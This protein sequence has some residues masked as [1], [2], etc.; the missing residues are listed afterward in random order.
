MFRQKFTRI[1]LSFVC[2]KELF[3]FGDLRSQFFDRFSITV[4]SEVTSAS[5]P[6]YPRDQ[7]WRKLGILLQIFLLTRLRILINLLL[8]R[9]DWQRS[10]FVLL[11]TAKCS[12][13]AI[14]DEDEFEVIEFFWSYLLKSRGASFIISDSSRQFP[15]SSWTSRTRLLVPIRDD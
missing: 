12:R 9:L 4:T 1:I 3:I 10:S 7:I 8:M 14:K 2:S 15:S 11:L 6:P 13:S 5:N